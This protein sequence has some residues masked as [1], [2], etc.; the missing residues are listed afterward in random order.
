MLVAI[1]RSASLFVIM[2]ISYS[3][4]GYGH[5]PRFPEKRGVVRP[6]FFSA[7]GLKVTLA[8]EEV[9]FSPE[10]RG[11]LA[12]TARGE[13][14]DGTQFERLDRLFSHKDRCRL[15]LRWTLR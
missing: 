6:V 14:G 1:A 9:A 11:T 10:D 15:N 12:K 13:L 8:L 2:S 5:R 3:L 7:T 4:R